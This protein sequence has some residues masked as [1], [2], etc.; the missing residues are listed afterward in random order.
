MD[1]LNEK[2]YTNL[3]QKA[4]KAENNVKNSSIYMNIEVPP[5]PR[6]SNR[7]KYTLWKKRNVSKC[8]IEQSEA[9]LF[10]SR[11]GFRYDRD[12]EAYQAIDLAREFKKKHGIKEN[13]IDKSKNFDHVFTKNDKNIM[14]RKSIQRVNLVYKDSENYNNIKD[15]ELLDMDTSEFYDEIN[16]REFLDEDEN[17]I[18]KITNITNITSVEPSAPPLDIYPCLDV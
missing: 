11:R 15:N 17:A 16:N 18:N 12:Y 8:V 3:L 14:R 5:P 13:D 10:L 1:K 9:V 7:D 2:I 6:P 4:N